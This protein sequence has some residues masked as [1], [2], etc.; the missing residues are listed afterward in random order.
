MKNFVKAMDRTGSA[1]KYLAE[2]FPRLSEAKIKEGVFVVPQIRKLFRDD[3]FNNLLQGDE[4]KACDVFRLV[5]A[6]FLGNIREENYKELMEDMLSLYYKLGCNMSLMIHMFFPHLDFF[7]DNCGM[8]SDEHGEIF[9]R[10]FQ[11]WRNDIRE[12]G[13]L[14]CWLTAVRRSPEMLLSSYTGDRQ[15]EVA[16]RSALSSLRV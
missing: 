11:R 13:P 3:V 8:V 2:K 6:N 14:P 15:N 4:K 5:S 16:R 7:P 1:F 10:N 9:I 12:S